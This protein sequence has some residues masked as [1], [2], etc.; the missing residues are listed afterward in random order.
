MESD[1]ICLATGRKLNF[2]KYIFG[3]IVRNVD[4]P[5]KFLM[6]PWFLQVIINAHVDDLSSHTNQYTS[7]AL[8][9][10]FWATVLIKKANDV[11]KLRALI[12][13]KRMVVTEDVIRQDLRLDDADGVE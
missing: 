9:Q 1:V 4:S 3:S 6:Y 13:G 2:S 8:T 5:S 10:K 11:V 12:D 7:P